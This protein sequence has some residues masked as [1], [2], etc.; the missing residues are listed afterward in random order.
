MGKAIYRMCL[1][2]L[3]LIAIAGGVY[4]YLTFFHEDENQDKGIFVNEMDFDEEEQWAV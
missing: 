1:V 4:Y 3:L 2:V